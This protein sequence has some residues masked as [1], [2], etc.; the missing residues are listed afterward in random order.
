M[1]SLM[2][3]PLLQMNVPVPMLPCQCPLS[4]PHALLCLPPHTHPLLLQRQAPL[5]LFLITQIHLQCSHLPILPQAQGLGLHF[6]IFLLLYLGACL[7][8]LLAPV[9]GS[10]MQRNRQRINS[11]LKLC[12]ESHLQMHLSPGL[13]QTTYK[14]FTSLSKHMPC[15]CFLFVCLFSVSICLFSFC[16]FFFFLR[17]MNMCL[18]F[19]LL[20]ITIPR[21]FYF[22]E[23]EILTAVPNYWDNSFFG[24]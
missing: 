20:T 6:C 18:M 3:S 14:I 15:V 1:P 19:V 12:P 13:P 9:S 22:T 10:H 5:R 21:S 24:A 17:N 23:C 16:F 7:H 2:Q 4:I 8:P 11:R